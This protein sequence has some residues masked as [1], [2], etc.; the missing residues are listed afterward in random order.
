MP[1]GPMRMAFKNNVRI[2]LFDE[3]LEALIDRLFVAFAKQPGVSMARV[4]YAPLVSVF[5]FN[6][7]APGEAIKVTP[8][9]SHLLGGGFDARP[10]DVFFDFHSSPLVHIECRL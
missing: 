6:G 5:K 10:I 9:A 2:V 8:I 1:N 7:T 3:R 4:P